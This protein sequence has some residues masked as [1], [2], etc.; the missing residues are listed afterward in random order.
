MFKHTNWTNFL[1]FG[2]TAFYILLLIVG[3]VEL[4]SSIFF[5]SS[6]VGIILG[7]FAVFRKS[8]RRIGAITLASVMLLMTLTYSIVDAQVAERDRLEQI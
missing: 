8:S 6:F 4:W 2:L 7:L 1:M 5:L 3:R